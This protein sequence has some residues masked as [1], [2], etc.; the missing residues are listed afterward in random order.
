MFSDDLR[1]QL[2]PFLCRS[3]ELWMACEGQAVTCAYICSHT[4]LHLQMLLD[5]MQLFFP[6]RGAQPGG[7]DNFT[8]LGN[9]LCG[10]SLRSCVDDRFDP[11]KREIKCNAAE[12]GG[13][14]AGMAVMPLTSAIREFE[15]CCPDDACLCVLHQSMRH[16]CLPDYLSLLSTE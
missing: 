14:P 3:A 8:L 1:T 12:A 10:G 4:R 7:N 2:K 13:C 9:C 15:V 16:G 6:L 5:A 11:P